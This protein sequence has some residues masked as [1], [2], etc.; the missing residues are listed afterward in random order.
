[1]EP[2]KA[3]R[4][5]CLLGK[6]QKKKKKKKK[7][8]KKITPGETSTFQNEEIQCGSQKLGIC[9]VFHSMITYRN[10]TTKL[11]SFPQKA[12]PARQTRSTQF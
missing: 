9:V 4:K 3:H 1:M 10:S 8:Q 6:Q 2:I 11:L 5:L 12:L 7:Q